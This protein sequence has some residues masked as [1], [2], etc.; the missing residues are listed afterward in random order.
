MGKV[1]TP[2]FKRAKREDYPDERPY[3]LGS[4]PWHDDEMIR[5]DGKLFVFTNA[6]GPDGKEAGMD[7]RFPGGGVCSVETLRA[8]GRHI[9]MPT[10]VRKDV[11][12]TRRG[13]E[14]GVA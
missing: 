4:A 1:E 6:I 2:D 11:Y 14:L 13:A 9:A 3:Y 5:V 8:Q 10:R 12:R 7:V